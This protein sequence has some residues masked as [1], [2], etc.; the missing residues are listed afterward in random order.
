MFYW[1]SCM[2]T[3]IFFLCFAY[4]V[5]ISV[6]THLIQGI[7]AN[8]AWRFSFVANLHCTWIWTW[9]TLILSFH[10][11]CSNQVPLS[12]VFISSAHHVVNYNSFSGQYPPNSV[13]NVFCCRSV[14]LP[15]QN[16]RASDQLKKLLAVC[17]KQFLN[18]LDDFEGF[19]W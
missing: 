19:G 16:Q 11:Q 14:P 10:I 12:F 17:G 6:Y 9:Q 15:N 5:H 1:T 8:V 13:G 18:L 4:Q 7:W 3:I 2:S